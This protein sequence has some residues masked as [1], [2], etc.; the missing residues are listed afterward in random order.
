MPI[1]LEISEQQIS[2]NLIAVEFRTSTQPTSATGLMHWVK[3]AE[4]VVVTR[5]LSILLLN[6][7]VTV[8]A[9]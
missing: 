6:D 5:G 4:P 9:M 1:A 3:V 7:Q 2:M 8:T